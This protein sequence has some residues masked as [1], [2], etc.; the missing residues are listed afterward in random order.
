MSLTPTILDQLLPRYRDVLSTEC[1]SFEQRSWLKLVFDKFANRP[2]HWSASDLTSF[3]CVSFPG[4]STPLVHQAGPV[5]Y[6][7]FLGVGSYPYHQDPVK[8]LDL[9]T[10]RT[11]IILLLGDDGQILPFIEDEEEEEGDE[12]ERASQVRARYPRLLFQSLAPSIHL[13][14]DE[15]SE[16]NDKDIAEA[17]RIVSQRRIL[18][19]PHNPKIGSRAPELPPSSALPPS[20]AELLN[21]RLTQTDL[22]SLVRLFLAC[23]LYWVG[24]RV[25]VGP[26]ESIATSFTSLEKATNA[27]LDTFD[28]DQKDLC[29]WGS[30][31]RVMAKLVPGVQTAMARI[32]HLFVEKPQSIN[33]NE[34]AALPL[35]EASALLGRSSRTGA[36]R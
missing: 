25:G 26:E 21:G 16:R 22:R 3:L 6:R 8:E 11:A 13:D 29:T 17:L 30:F 33:D 1:L 9:D 32:L 7:L 18:R 24:D 34:F 31:H 27:I 23:Q 19:H 4:T 36:L 14:T 20:H 15:R 2:G 10:L 5:L 12:N 35:V 28:L